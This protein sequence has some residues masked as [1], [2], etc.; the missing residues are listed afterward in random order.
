MQQMLEQLQGMLLEANVRKTNAQAAQAEAA[1]V[2]SQTDASVKVAQ[3]TEP[4][5]APETQVR[6][7]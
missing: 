6:V 4:Q 3:F 7:S 2:E 1:A 5:V